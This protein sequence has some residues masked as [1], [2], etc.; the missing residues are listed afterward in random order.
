MYILYFVYIC[1]RK[2][3]VTNP[4]NLLHSGYIVFPFARCLIKI[5][6]E[7]IQC[8]YRAIELRKEMERK[9]V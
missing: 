3:G 5:F 2:G 6:I 4:Q 8:K 7:L 9:S 1:T